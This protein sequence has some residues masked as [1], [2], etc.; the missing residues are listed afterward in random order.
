[1]EHFVDIGDGISGLV[2]ISQLS[3]KRVK[4]PEEVVKEGDAV[5]V[6][7]TLKSQMEK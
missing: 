2:H 3:Q 7:S 1:M 5:T 6:K 4:S